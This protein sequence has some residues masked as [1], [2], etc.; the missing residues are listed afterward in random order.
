M[1]APQEL[2]G[3]DL[4]AGIDGSEL[5]NGKARESG[6]ANGS[7]RRGRHRPQARRAS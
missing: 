3:P 5:T 2:K 4:A 6:S 1:G 7:N